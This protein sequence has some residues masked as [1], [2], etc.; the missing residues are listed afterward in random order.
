MV[1]TA[2]L[3][4]GCAQANDAGSLMQSHAADLGSFGDF[5]FRA[6][7]LS[8]L[9][10]TTKRMESE[11]KAMATALI[12]KQ[13]DPA[14]GNPFNA[15]ADMGRSTDSEGPFHYVKEQFNMILLQLNTEKQTNQALID[16]AVGKL[17]TCNS[18][19]DT[20]YEEAGGVTDKK[21]ASDTARGVHSTCRQTEHTDISARQDSCGRFVANAVCNA[22][23]GNY[24]FFTK[25]V[26]TNAYLN[27]N[28]GSNWDA[29]IPAALEQTVR[30]A[31]E[32][33]SELATELVTAA[34]CDLQQA[35]FENAFCAYATKL[36]ETENTYE[37]CW[38]TMKNYYDNVILGVTSLEEEQKLIYQTVQ[39]LNCYVTKMN[40]NFKN[41]TNAIIM[42]CEDP[43]IGTRTGESYVNQ[44]NH[45]LYLTKTAA[46]AKEPMDMSDLQ[47]GW[48]GQSTWQQHEYNQW[49][50]GTHHHQI[51]YGS[52]H[53]V[54]I[55]ETMQVC[56]VIQAWSA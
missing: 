32:C 29:A 38:Y 51:Y 18:N 41:L 49:T 7:K 24:S 25:G 8:E 35:A 34:H 31:K 1:R 20:H 2:F 22:H 21:S 39:K 55:T 11:Y 15:P 36:Q 5:N 19:K 12:N 52:D 46:P 37:E 30:E 23:Q 14:T 45:T 56:S 13:V 3:V 6:S 28:D 50:V 40:A 17:N 54:T 16:G 47:Y 27:N 33:K 26:A 42:T 9:K 44:A 43:P 48:V 4:F 10:V 53:N